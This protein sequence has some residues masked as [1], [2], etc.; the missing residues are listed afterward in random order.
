P[1]IYVY[2]FESEEWGTFELYNPTYTEGVNSAGPVY[3]DAL[4]WDY[5]GEY[6]VYDCFNRIDNATGA[7]IEYWD[8]NFIHVWDGEAKEFADGSIEKLFSSLPDGVSIGNPSFAKNSP[9]IIA[10][11]YVDE[12]TDEY[13]VLGCNIETN[14]VNVIAENNTLGWPS[15][16]KND[17]RV[18]FT[19]LDTDSEYAIN[20]I[21]L[22]S[23]KIS[24][25]GGVVNLLE[26]KKWPVYFATG[27]REIG[28]EVITDVLDE[29]NGEVALSC[30]P[31]PFGNEISLLLKEPLI[32]GSK[33]EINNSMGQRVFTYTAESSGNQALPLDLANLKPGYYILR[34]SN[35]KKVGSCKIVKR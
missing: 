4:E 10:F 32:A 18:A 2:D 26:L 3:A 19:A 24:S 8:V 30:Y 34:I 33:I 13:A 22:N 1:E 20:Y 29:T 21:L 5:T 14:E 15:F 17:S 11:D 23:D 6:L 9:N 7:D 31:N 27:E 16:N 35:A 12:G 25:S 28:E